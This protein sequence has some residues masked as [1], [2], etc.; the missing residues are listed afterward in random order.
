MVDEDLDITDHTKYTIV[1]T[2]AGLD[3]WV[4][5]HGPLPAGLAAIHELGTGVDFAA[6][7][8]APQED[9]VILVSGHR[10]LDS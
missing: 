5:Q 3:A 10:P 7:T 4:Q 2:Y 8:E 9:G 6:F 1:H